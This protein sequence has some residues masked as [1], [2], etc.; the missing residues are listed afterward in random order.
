MPDATV[1]IA[2]RDRA[3]LLCGCLTALSEQTAAG[4]F[5]VVVVDNG[6]TDD[7]AL[8]VTQ[9][10]RFGVRSV[11]VDAPNRAKA[12][13]AG[14]AAAQGAILIFCDDDTL[15][16]PHFV[17]A[18]VQA[19]RKHPDSVVTGP[20]INISDEISRPSAGLQYYS[21][22]FFCTCNV[23]VG[24]THVEAVGGFDER[25][26]LYGWE[27][28]DLGIRL[29]ARGLRRAWSWDAY[30]YHLKPQ[31]LATLA[32]RVSLAREKGFMAARFVRKSP[33][34]PV[35]FA[36][37]AY[38]ANFIRAAILGTQPLRNLYQRIAQ[39]ER[40]AQTPLGTWARESIVDTEY[41]SALRR[42]LGEDGEV[43]PG[44]ESPHTL[45]SS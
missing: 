45:H 18:H 16:P 23:S 13:N 22:A 8:I 42:A 17:A 10:E 36:T 2:T 43:E 24:K 4:S 7:T 26:D 35:K 11:F 28:T 15:A 20:I 34:W 21:R 38:S 44:H 31:A 5:D 6:S 27:D 39:D 32:R 30:L 1:V 3:S 40:L 19:H 25:Y 37:G 12:R 14:I 9:F 33:T 29:R 41:V